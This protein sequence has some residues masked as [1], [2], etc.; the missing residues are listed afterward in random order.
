MLASHKFQRVLRVRYLF[1]V[2][3]IFVQARQ[4]PEPSETS[5]GDGQ[6]H[7]GRNHSE[8][9]ATPRS[10]VEGEPEFGDTARIRQD[11][12]AGPALESASQSQ[13]KSLQGTKYS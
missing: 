2:H 12:E 11:S 1:K 7:H 5:Q 3:I 10:R 6:S 4:Q 13:G 8:A 9:P